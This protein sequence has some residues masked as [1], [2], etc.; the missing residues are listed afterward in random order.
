MRKV[1]S[2]W[3]WILDQIQELDW[4]Y[5]G[6]ET[7]QKNGENFAK[8]HTRSPNRITDATGALMMSCGGVF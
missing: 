3:F 6:A 1:G 7:V 4:E 5:L 2:W 8:V